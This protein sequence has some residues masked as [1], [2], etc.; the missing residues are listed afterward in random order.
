MRI[1]FEISNPVYDVTRSEFSSH[2][3]ERRERADI[4]LSTVIS[5]MI[6]LVP[7][8]ERQN[9]K[10]KDGAGTVHT[11]E[12]L[13]QVGEIYRRDGKIGLYYV[14]K[15]SAFENIEENDDGVRK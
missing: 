5:G 12:S 9:I 15:D 6:G 7:P 13:E 2:P 3:E 10:V 11:F 4:D 1:Q 14:G 8:D